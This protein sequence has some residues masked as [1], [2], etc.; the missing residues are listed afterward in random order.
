VDGHSG[1]EEAI[2]AAG[3][4]SR[5]GAALGLAHTSILKW[6][7]SGIPAERVPAVEAATGVPRQR[8]RPDLF[9]VSAPYEA[10][11]AALGLDAAAL[12]EQAVRAAI[13]A[14]KARRWLE[15][16]REAISDW[17]RWTAENE[18]PLAKYRVF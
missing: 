2:A 8:L 17:N 11:A 15:E 7:R 16:N 9:A 13:S 3:G 10:E 18:L 5:L 12:A 4:V 14:E 1:I 6:R